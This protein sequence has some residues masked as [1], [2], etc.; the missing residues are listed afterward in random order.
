MKLTQVNYFII[1]FILLVLQGIAIDLLPSSLTTSDVLIVPHWL[2]LFLTL[3]AI[4]YDRNETFYAIIYAIIFG[5]LIDI[6]YTGTL[7]IYMFVYPVAVY[8]AH[9]LKRMFQTNIVVSSL[10]AMISIAVAEV[11][12]Y[13]IYKILGMIDATMS[14]FLLYRLLPT[15]FAN[16]L[17]FLVIYGIFSQL[18]VRW[19][20]EQLEKIS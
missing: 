13:Y 12:I 8:T 15:S 14:Y 16:L 3:I 10:I 17:F 5:L 19:S 6:V 2:L 7:G 18:L 9:I 1:L 20:N 11:L 4:K